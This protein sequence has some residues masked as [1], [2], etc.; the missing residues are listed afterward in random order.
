MVDGRLIAN[1]VGTLFFFRYPESHLGAEHFLHK[2]QTNRLDR[3]ISLNT[4]FHQVLPGVVHFR[5]YAYSHDVGPGGRVTNG[6]FMAGVTNLGTLRIS[7]DHKYMQFHGRE[8]PEYLELELG[9]MEPELIERARGIANAQTQRE[10]LSNRVDRIH[11]FRHK[12]P[13]RSRI[14][15]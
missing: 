15:Q 7:D 14:Q 1:G 2:F 11:F 8:L 3:P 6:V 12:I 4:N 9:I 5:V 13:I 10:F